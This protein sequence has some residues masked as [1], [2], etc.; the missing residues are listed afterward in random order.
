MKKTTK[1]GGNK[2]LAKVVTLVVISMVV[3]NGVVGFFE[4]LVQNYALAVIAYI[5]VI[6]LINTKLFEVWK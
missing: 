3:A 5:T 6:A 1:Q 4:Q 2:A